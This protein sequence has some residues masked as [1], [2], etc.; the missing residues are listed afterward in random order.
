MSY[1]MTTHEVRAAAERELA[2]QYAMG[3]AQCG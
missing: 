1:G 3:G 2:R